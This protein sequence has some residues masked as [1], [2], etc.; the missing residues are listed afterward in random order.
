MSAQ[1][2]KS[3]ASVASHRQRAVVPARRD[4]LHAPRVVRPAGH[5]LIQPWQ[6]ASLPEL[7]EMMDQMKAAPVLPDDAR[8]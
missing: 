3:A 7:L 4:S 1:H 6:T 8:W 5:H 2:R